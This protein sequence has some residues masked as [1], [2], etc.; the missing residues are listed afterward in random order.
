QV[1]DAWGQ[2]ELGGIV[3][4]T[5]SHGPA[6]S[7][8]TGTLP[9]CGLDIVDPGCHSVPVGITGEAVLRLPWAGT[10][11]GVEGAQAPVVDTHWTRHPG[12]SSTGDLAVRQPAGDVS[13][14]GRTDD[15]VS[16]SGQLVSLREVREVLAEHPYVSGAEVTWR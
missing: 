14:L 15:V 6:P 16:V 5:D 3:R 8:A 12:C 4:V 1:S 7:G 2:L 11:V 13:F 10:L 9:D